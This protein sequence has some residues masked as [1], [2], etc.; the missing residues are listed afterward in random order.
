MFVSIWNNLWSW[1]DSK[2]LALLSSWNTEIATL[3]LQIQPVN[4][5]PVFTTILDQSVSEDNNFYI[6]LSAVDV[7]SDSLVYHFE[8]E[9]VGGN[10]TI[11]DNLLTIVLP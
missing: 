2:R 4:D 7:D 6:N 3:N 8:D 5:A 9:I 10:G 11:T 1:L